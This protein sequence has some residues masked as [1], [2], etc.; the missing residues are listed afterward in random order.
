[1]ADISLYLAGSLTVAIAFVHGYLGA[2]KV[3]GPSTAPSA[4]AKRIL[5]A[6][7]FLSAVYWFVGGVLLIAAPAL[8][9]GEIRKWVVYG[10]AA[11]LV[12]GALGNMWGTRGKHFGGYFLLLVGGLA[13]FG[14]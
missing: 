12:S 7:M 9:E 2:T 14:A 11:M 3:V 13:V 5:H 1:M 8:F 6:I 10:I 4:S